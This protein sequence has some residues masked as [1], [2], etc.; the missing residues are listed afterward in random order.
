MH[1]T[2]TG[3]SDEQEVRRMVVFVLD[4]TVI[5]IKEQE[6]ELRPVE[7]DTSL[8]PTEFISLEVE[9]TSF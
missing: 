3:Y 6:Q 7:E 1:N 8:S 2:V 9:I 5:S 4:T